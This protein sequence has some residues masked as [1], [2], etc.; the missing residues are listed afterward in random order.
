MTAA[1]RPFP[2]VLASASPRRRA[3]LAQLG[4]E[5]R[6]VPVNVDESPREGET[7]QNYVERLALAKGRAALGQIRSSGAAVIAADTAV[8]IDGEILG[9][10]AGRDDAARM[11]TRLSGAV[12]EVRTTV[13]VLRAG[14]ERCAASLSRVRFRSLSRE[15]IAAY[16]ATGEP[17]DKAG[18]YAIQGLGAVFVESIEG[19]YSGIVGLPLFETA[20]LLAMFGYDVLTLSR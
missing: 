1:T 10:P 3:L 11:L 13:A 19:S 7:P 5:C 8:I 20:R 12:H 14:H 18:A 15:E 2:V 17:L 16:S 6:T 9:K 4:I